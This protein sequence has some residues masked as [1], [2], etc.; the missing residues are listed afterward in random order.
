[1]EW[2]HCGLVSSRFSGPALAARYTRAEMSQLPSSYQKNPNP[3]DFKNAM[4]GEVCEWLAGERRSSPSWPIG[5]VLN[6]AN[7]A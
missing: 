2:E 7:A 1:M 4:K 6:R 5:A 3:L